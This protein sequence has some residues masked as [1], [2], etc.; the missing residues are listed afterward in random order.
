[1]RFCLLLIHLGF[2][3]GGEVE[4]DVR[5]LLEAEHPGLGGAVRKLLE[6]HAGKPDALHGGPEDRPA[7]V[8]LYLVFEIEVLKE[9]LMYLSPTL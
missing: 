1:M 8:M 6:S 2:L 9:Q 3:L 4:E 7:N 5:G